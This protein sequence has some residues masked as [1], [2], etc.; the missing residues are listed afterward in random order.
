MAKRKKKS[1]GMKAEEIR[2]AVTK[3]IVESIE[4]GNTLPWRKPWTGDPNC[5][6]PTRLS[7][8]HFYRGINTPV[9]Y[10]V[11]LTKN[12]ASKWWGTYKQISEL[13]G[14]VKQGEKS[15]LVVF[16]SMV[17][18]TDKD[19]GEKKTIPLMRHFRVFNIDQ[20]EGVKLDKFRVDPGF[21]VADPEWSRLDEIIDNK[22]V[23]ITHS[24]V[25]R[26]Y[27]KSGTNE[28]H[29]P[30]KSHFPVVADYYTTKLHEFC[31]W[32]VNELEIE[33]EYGEEELVVELAASLLCGELNLP[34]GELEN[35]ENY[36]ASWLKNLGKDPKFV[37]TIT[38]HAYKVMDFVREAEK[39][40]ENDESPRV[41]A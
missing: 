29:M 40:T 4:S 25:R 1:A 22:P 18:I 27:Y 11:G 26:A 20:T 41:A 28:I 3:S 30:N 5:G 31:H 2:D 32:C 24:D 14:N 38:R 19:T 8:K 39:E 15:T 36:I 6:L 13:G 23:V 7:N 12:Y 21:T 34:V 33:L 10:C 16:Y 35:H 37:F 17:P 9:L